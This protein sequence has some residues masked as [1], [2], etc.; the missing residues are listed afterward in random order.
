MKPL[1]RFPLS[2]FKGFLFLAC[3]VLPLGMLVRSQILP[4][5]PIEGVRVTMFSDEG[6]KV[7]NLKGSSALYRDDGA[8]EVKDMDLEIFQGE[9]G[10]QVDMHIL[11]GEAVYFADERSISG[12]GG[13]FVA[14]EFY[15]IQG[16]NWQYSQ[17]D[18]IVHVNSNVKVV[19]DYELDAFLK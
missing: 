7:W 14:G 15:Q 9:G 3:L 19:I 5:A 18:R 4:D 13:V 6:S 12:E 17:S 1:L 2:R 16:D 8:V 10:K 11:G